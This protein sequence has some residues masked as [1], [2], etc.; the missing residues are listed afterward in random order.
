MQSTLSRLSSAF[1]LMGLEFIPSR[2]KTLEELEVNYLKS[3]IKQQNK[4]LRMFSRKHTYFDDD[5]NPVLEQ[6]SF[7]MVT[8]LVCQ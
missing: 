5:G 7:L 3:N 8:I 4:D 2:S 1:T 6:V